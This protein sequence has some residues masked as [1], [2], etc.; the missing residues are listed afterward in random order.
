M[1]AQ[2][3]GWKERSTAAVMVAHLAGTKGFSM[4]VL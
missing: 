4:V 2:S 3:V 1:A